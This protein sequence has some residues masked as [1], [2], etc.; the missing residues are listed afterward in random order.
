[1]GSEKVERIAVLGAGVMGHSIAQIAA[2]AG[3]DVTIRDIDQR[4]LDGA[5]QMIERNLN[6]NVERGRMTEDAAEALM[7]RIKYTLDLRGA[8]EDADLVVEAIPE[9]LE[10]KKKV[11]GEVA[12]SVRGDA[13]LATNTSSLSITEIAEA[14][15]EPGRFVGMHFFNP[16]THMRL[17]EVIPGAETKPQSVDVVKAVSEKLGKTPVVVNKDVVGF[18]VNRV[19]ITYLNEATRLLESGSTRGTRS[20]APCS[21][22]RGCHSAP[23]C[24][25]TSSASTSST[26]SSRCSRRT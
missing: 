11:W 17:V 10:L 8:V 1:M 15:T 3:Y 25:P 4:F 13:V 21:T 6:R 26:T 20:T 18:I 22:K 9:N 12:A 5:R 24:S 19:L 14:V 7:G 2:G 16:P 23:S